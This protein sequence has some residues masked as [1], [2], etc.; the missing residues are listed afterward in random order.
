MIKSHVRSNVSFQKINQSL[1][2]CTSKDH[3]AVHSLLIGD[4]CISTA[5]SLN[6]GISQIHNTFGILSRAQHP[7]TSASLIEYHIILKTN[8]Y[9][10]KQIQNG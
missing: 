7:N 10:L 1:H 4:N 8:A 5:A 9:I 2:N 6:L 3:G